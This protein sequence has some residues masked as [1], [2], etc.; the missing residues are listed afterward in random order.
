MPVPR[1]QLSLK[2]RALRLQAQREHSLQEL[3]RKLAAHE[4]EPGEIERVLDELQKRGW[5]NESR[6]AESLAYRRGPR[7]GTAKLIREMQAKGLSQDTIASAVE[8][9]RANEFSRAQAVWQRKFGTPAT[10]AQE[11]A[12]QI[13]FL[14]SR[15]F[16]AEV[17]RQA[18]A[19]AG[20]DLPD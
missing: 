12:R 9:L 6:V 13:R 18:V 16:S 15:G 7:L 5:V 17:I 14:A 8:P 11:R 2:G 1:P 19:G 20:D 4:T 10:S 3:R